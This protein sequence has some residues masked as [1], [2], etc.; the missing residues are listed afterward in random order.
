MRK[1]N[2]LLCLCAILMLLTACRSASINEFVGLSSTEFFQQ[3]PK[4]DCFLYAGYTFFLN[5]QGDSCVVHFEQ[6]GP[7]DDAKSYSKDTIDRSARAFSEIVPG[8]TIYE[9][10]EKV[11]IPTDS[12]TSGL[13]S[14]AFSVEEGV[15][16]VI[17]DMSV[18]PATVI[19]VSVE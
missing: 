6:A 18:Y 17:L 16:T 14:L 2:I 12:R 9:V 5:E 19:E 4:E 11:G 8:M 1:W 7:I 10:V 3:V 13:D 15:Y